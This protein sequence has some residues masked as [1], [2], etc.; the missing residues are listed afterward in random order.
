MSNRWLGAIASDGWM[1]QLK[2]KS[3]VPVFVIRYLRRMIGSSPSTVIVFSNRAV[4]MGVYEI[5]RSLHRRG[6]ASRITT[7]VG[8]DQI[9]P[10]YGSSEPYRSREG[11]TPGNAS[12][13]PPAQ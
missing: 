1:P 12:A 11:A 13:H 2:S 4:V 10:M 6:D 5:R 8:C 9:S 3:I 7:S